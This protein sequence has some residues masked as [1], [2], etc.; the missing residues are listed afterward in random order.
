MCEQREGKCRESHGK[1]Q[2]KQGRR[3]IHQSE[4]NAENKVKTSGKAGSRHSGSGSAVVQQ[5]PWSVS[6]M[7][8]VSKIKAE[9]I[10]RIGN[11][12]CWLRTLP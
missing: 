2:E 3:G 7:N 12:S 11:P 10:K 5:E 8:V 4:G 6:N 9:R 1:G